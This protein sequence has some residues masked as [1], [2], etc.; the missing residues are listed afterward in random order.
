MSILKAK[1]LQLLRFYDKRI[2][3]HNEFEDLTNLRK[4]I[5]D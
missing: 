5:R 4:G 1:N 2:M 3:S